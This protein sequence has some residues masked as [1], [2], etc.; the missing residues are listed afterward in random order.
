MREDAPTWETDVER[1]SYPAQRGRLDVDVAIIGGGITGLTTAYH[2]AGEGKRVAVLEKGQIAGSASGLTTAF[3]TRV[4]DTDTRDLIESS[5]R[6]FTESLLASHQRAIDSV[7]AIC[8]V[9][10]IDCEFARCPLY[11]YANG[12]DELESVAQEARAMAEA[13]VNVTFSPTAAPGFR[14]AGF[15]TVPDQAKFHPLKYLLGLAAAASER[16]AMIFESTEV[17]ALEGEGPFELTTSEGVVR[18]KLVVSA[19][20][21]PY[22][23]PLQLF[24]QKGFYVTYMMELEVRN[25]ELEEAIYEDTANP[26]RYFRVDGEGRVII[27][28]EDHRH[29]IHMDPATNF[30]ELEE[31]ARKIFGAENVTVRRRWSGPILEPADG[32]AYIGPL[33]NPNLI[34][35]T[36]FSGT[37]MTY[38]TI[39]GRLIADLVV[40][41]ANGDERLYRANR[42]PPFKRLWVK[43]RDYLGELWG[44]AIH[45]AL[46][47]KKRGH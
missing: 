28:G 34:Y 2:L 10:G 6:E 42:V 36:A 46:H 11:L 43:G 29:E 44:G 35:A 39:A 4:L 31:Y 26:Y 12:P 13:G 45:N 41:R 9:E 20:N 21:K 7:E 14:N 23:Q 37:G 15:A 3:I 40:G 27:G 38:G 16:G 32:L 1:Q 33:S 8:K 19:T 24:F 18:A 47:Q 22:G 25:L 30:A 17:T 5:G